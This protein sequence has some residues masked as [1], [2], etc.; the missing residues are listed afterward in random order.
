MLVNSVSISEVETIVL[1]KLSILIS[2]SLLVCSNLFFKFL[3]RQF[4]FS[5]VLNH[6]WNWNFPLNYFF[7]R[8]DRFSFFLY[9]HLTAQFR[10]IAGIHLYK[11]SLVNSICICDDSVFNA[12]N[13]FDWL[14]FIICKWIAKCL[15]SYPVM[16]IYQRIN[17]DR[18]LF[19]RWLYSSNLLDKIHILPFFRFI[20]I[21]YFQRIVK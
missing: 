1:L 3:F 4:F 6:S 19:V 5:Y 8:H 11:K 9:L 16:N 20:L 12:L 18:N 7:L 21:K 2:W 10:T 14:D 15:S 17:I 13:V